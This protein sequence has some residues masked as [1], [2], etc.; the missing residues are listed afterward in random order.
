M[1]E[2]GF[3]YVAPMKSKSEVILFLKQFSKEIGSPEV[4]ITDAAHEKKYQEV[5]QFLNIIGIKLRVLE[6]GTT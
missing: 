2:K 6:E 5:K 4:A 1:T 3:T